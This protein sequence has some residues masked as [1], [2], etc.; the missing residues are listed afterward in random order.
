MAACIK[1]AKAEG[2]NPV[3]LNVSF[4]GT[5]ALL[6][7]LGAAGD[8]VIITQVMPS[9]GDTSVPIVAPYPRD[10]KAAGH[11][12]LDFTDLDGHVDAARF[13]EVLKEVGASRTLE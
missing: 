8:G 13:V 12:D 5:A 7:E 10:M 1:K 9:P 11:A 6:R 2:F 4:V 3:F